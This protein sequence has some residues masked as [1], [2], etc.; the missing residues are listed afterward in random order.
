MSWWNTGSISNAAG[1]ASGVPWLAI[2]T[3][4]AGVIG[5]I[6]SAVGQPDG[7]T[8]RK[9]FGHITN[10]WAS[11]LGNQMKSQFLA[12]ANRGFASDAARLNWKM[13]DVTRRVGP[14]ILA[15]SGTSGGRAGFQ[16]GG[17]GNYTGLGEYK[18]YGS[19]LGT[20]GT[21]AENGT[22][23]KT[24]TD[25]R[26]DIPEYDGDLEMG[27]AMSSSSG[28]GH[29]GGTMPGRQSQMSLRGMEGGRE[30]GSS[31]M[32]EFRR[33]KRMRDQIMTEG[34]LHRGAGPPAGNE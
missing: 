9:S 25:T 11:F 30:S 15:W 5:G 17:G 7:P 13:P 10:N 8:P 6:G 16:F 34:K 29:S 18:P 14:G 1:A 4:A 33:V 26:W 12:S 27:G 3:L 23:T 24:T 31:R 19:G 22:T 2:A 32:N 21:T 28:F 20:Y